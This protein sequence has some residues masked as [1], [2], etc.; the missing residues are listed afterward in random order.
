[1]TAHAPF[2]QTLRQVARLV[3]VAMPVVLVTLSLMVFAATAAVGA[4]TRRVT[5][6][7]HK[8]LA[9]VR[10]NDMDKYPMPPA[11]PPLVAL[12][13]QAASTGIARVELLAVH[14]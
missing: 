6:R 8:A 4:W 9:W 13:P 12:V 2:A 1:M 3:D 11:D 10:P 14:R 5:A 7:E